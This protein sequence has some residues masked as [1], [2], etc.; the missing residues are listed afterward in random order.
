MDR[1]VLRYGGHHGRA[2]GSDLERVSKDPAIRIVDR[3][4]AGLALVEMTEDLLPRLR[5]LL[6]G[7]AIEKEQEIPMPEAWPTRPPDPRTS[8][9]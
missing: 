1:Y 7:W 4:S 2:P 6:P 5:T 3:A 9:F 8:G